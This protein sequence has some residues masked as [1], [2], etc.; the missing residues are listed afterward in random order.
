M[1]R[2]DTDNAFFRRRQRKPLRVGAGLV[3]LAAALVQASLVTS[4]AQGLPDGAKPLKAFEMYMIYKDKTWLWKNGA[5]R[6]FS[7]DRKFLAW[8]SDE[9]EQTVAE[10]RY[11]LTNDGRMCMDALWTGESYS[12]RVKTCFDHRKDRGTIYQKREGDSGWY[13]FRDREVLPTDE[14]NKLIDDDEVTARAGEIRK[15]LGAKNQT[16]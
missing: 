9:D 13:V 16:E 12:K 8:T 4:S 10:G 2:Q 7:G 3:C 15:M 6:F 14:A 11:T 1:S 5:G